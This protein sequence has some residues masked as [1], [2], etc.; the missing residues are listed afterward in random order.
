MTKRKLVVYFSCALSGLPSEHRAT[1]IA[2]REKFKERYTV[3]EF[4]T[5]E[6]P[7]G[8]LYRHDIHYC[9]RV[10]DFLIAICDERSTGLGYEMSTGIEKHRKPAIAFAHHD[11]E[12]TKVVT[13][14]DYPDFQFS[15]YGDASEIENLVYQFEE[16]IFG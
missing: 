12:V 4:C 14:I 16:K 11:A 1:M 10:A 3:L 6:T 9:C 7:A 2:I 8:D 5:P 15:R 13:G